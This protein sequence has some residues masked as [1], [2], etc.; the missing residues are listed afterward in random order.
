VSAI[1]LAGALVLT[2]V[3]AAMALVV[4]AT[5]LRRLPIAGAR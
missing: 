3:T 1:E 2:L 5:L 4:S